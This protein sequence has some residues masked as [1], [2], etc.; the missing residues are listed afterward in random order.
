MIRKTLLFA[1]VTALVLLASPAAAVTNSSFNAHFKED[2]SKKAVPGPGVGQVRGYG[3]ATE[4]FEFL[5]GTPYDPATGCAGSTARTTI[6][7]ADGSSIRILETNAIC[8]PGKSEFSNSSPRSWGNPERFSGTWSVDPAYAP[9]GAFADVCGG[10]GTQR[11]HLAG[12]ALV[13]AYE[14]TL[15]RC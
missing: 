10:Q 13:A 7:L 2:W 9:T 14:G 12:G 1:A 8:F 11:G 5:S 4:S 3:K 6:T 15:E